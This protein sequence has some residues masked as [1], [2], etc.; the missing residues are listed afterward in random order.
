M[1]AKEGGL[2]HQVQPDIAAG[3]RRFETDL[4]LRVPVTMTLLSATAPA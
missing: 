3:F 4:G 1:R 2:K